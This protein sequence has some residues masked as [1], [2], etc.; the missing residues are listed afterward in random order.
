MRVSKTQDRGLDW[1]RGLS[2]FS[3]NECCFRVTVRDRVRVRVNTNRK[4]NLALTL[5]VTLKHQKKSLLLTTY[6]NFKFIF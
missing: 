3:F 2:L 4:P 5:T 6:V 1:G